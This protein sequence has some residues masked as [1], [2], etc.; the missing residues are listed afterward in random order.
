MDWNRTCTR[1]VRKL[2]S[3]MIP[4][5]ELEIGTVAEEWIGTALRRFPRILPR[6]KVLPAWRNA[7]YP[8]E[9]PT[10]NLQ[11]LPPPLRVGKGSEIGIGDSVIR[12]GCTS[13]TESTPVVR[14]LSPKTAYRTTYWI[15]ISAIGMTMSFRYF[16]GTTAFLF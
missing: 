16:H 2:S 5:L 4:R 12:R 9:M 10:S 13:C 7:V 11:P 1:R 14:I 8:F 6:K 15:G 3:Y